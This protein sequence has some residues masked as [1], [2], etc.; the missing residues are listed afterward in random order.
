M[1][2]SVTKGNGKAYQWVRDHLTYEGNQCLRWPF[3]YDG[4]VGRGRLGWNGKSYW[5]H[6]LM[7]E[8]AHGSA[9]EGKDQVAHSC[10]ERKEKGMER[11]DIK[12]PAIFSGCSFADTIMPDGSTLS[13]EGEPIVLE[14]ANIVF[15]AEWTDDQRRDFRATHNLPGPEW[16]S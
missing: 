8:L 3:S 11:K 14:R 9:P 5:A 16:R 2:N 7:C 6:R 10:R 15:P 12:V 13:A 1:T 4:G